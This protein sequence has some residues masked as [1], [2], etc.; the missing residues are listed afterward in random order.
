MLYENGQADGYDYIA[1]E[2]VDGT[3]A[4]RLINTRGILPVRRSTEIIKQVAIALDHAQQQGVVHRDIKPA[5]LLIR[6]DG[7]VKLADMG[8][9]RIVDETL[10]TGITRAGTTVG[11]VDYMSPEQARD[12]KA[13]DIRSDLYSLGCTWYF[14]LT[15]EPPFP[16][17][18]SRTSCGPTR[19]SRAPIRV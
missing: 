13:A 16:R 9:A 17:G 10:D 19:R 5:N 11:T 15:G 14:L 2:Y 12:S 1:L 3:D 18:R 8:L 4:A 7:V 6:R